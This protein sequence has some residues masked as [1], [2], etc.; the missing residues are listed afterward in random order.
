[1]THP[2]RFLIRMV[3]FLLVVAAAA[4]A[5]YLPLMTAFLANA[6]LNGLIL[7][8][9]ALG[10]LYNVRQVLQLSPE[11]TWIERFRTR[12]KAHAASTEPAAPPR[13]LAPLAAMVGNREEIKISAMALR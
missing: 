8:V 4:A 1:M 5:V 9:F 11:L 3:L 12:V 2:R 13:L 7:G 10:A 6:A